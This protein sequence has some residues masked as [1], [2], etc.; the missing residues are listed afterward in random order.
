MK[1][2][3]IR[4]DDDLHAQLSVLAQLSESTITEEIRKAIETHLDTQAKNPEL[5]NRAQA[6][7]DTIEREADA[8]KAAIA[9]MFGKSEPS[10]TGRSSKRPPAKNE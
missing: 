5:T 3:A 8:R 6:V 10:G 1:T 4:L 2:L 7:L 9:T